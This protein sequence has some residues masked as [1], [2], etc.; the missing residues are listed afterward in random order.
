MPNSPPC[1]WILIPPANCALDLKIGGR[2]RGG[3]RL[4][5]RA[6]LTNR[7]PPPVSLR[8]RAFAKQ[9]RPW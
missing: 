2:Q 5:R 4:R 8:L 6:R 9:T 1:L 7:D 3:G